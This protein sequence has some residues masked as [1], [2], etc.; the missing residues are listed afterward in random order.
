MNAIRSLRVLFVSR[1]LFRNWL[2]A[3]IKYYLAR[4]GVFR[5]DFIGVV[6]LDGSRDS[7][8][9]HAYGV[10]V[11]DYYDGF[12]RNYDCVEHMA[13]YGDTKIPIGEV[14]IGVGQAI[15]SGWT[16]S[17]E[18]GYWFRGGVRFRHA[19]WTILEVFD[20]GIYEGVDVRGKTVIDV[21]AFVGDS[22]IYFALRVQGGL[23]PLS[24]TLGL[25]PR[26]SRTLG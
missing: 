6:C 18:G 10:L 9:T 22:A 21:G 13:I 26:C 24:L 3:G 17:I 15:K 7:I 5:G 19:H 20:W 2:P 4:R 25:T 16:Y 11:N 1:G 14:N 23:L 8:P 12:L